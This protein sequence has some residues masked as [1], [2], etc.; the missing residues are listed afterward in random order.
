[1]SRALP[2]QYPMWCLRVPPLPLAVT[3]QK[4]R[5]AIEAR[6]QSLPYPAWGP[7][8]A[9]FFLDSSAAGEAKQRALKGS[10]EQGFGTRVGPPMVAQPCEEGQ[11]RWSRRLRSKKGFNYYCCQRCGTKWRVLTQKRRTELSLL[12]IAMSGAAPPHT[13]Q[14]S[15]S[16]LA[17]MA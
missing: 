16:R 10:L 7:S 14:N 3:S 1:M 12:A 17:L 4:L 9:M 8:P 5:Q 13:A 15:T 2:P 6:L 11:H